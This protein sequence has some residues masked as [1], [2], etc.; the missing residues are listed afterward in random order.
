MKKYLLIVVVGISAIGL[1]WFSK[2]SKEAR[3]E[4]P[5]SERLSLPKIRNQAFPKEKLDP[6]KGEAQ[7]AGATP[8]APVADEKSC[9]T[10]R[11]NLV[12]MDVATLKSQV[13]AGSLKIM[14]GCE[15]WEVPSPL[16][17]MIKEKCKSADIKDQEMCIG[18]MTFYRSL[19]M[20]KMTQNQKDYLTMDIG[21]L[22]NKIYAGFDESKSS[23][24][25]KA[26]FQKMTRALVDRHPYSIQ[27]HKALIGS[28]IKSGVNDPKGFDYK[29]IEAAA[30][31]AMKVNPDEG[32]VH[33]A[34]L[35]AQMQKKDAQKVN[36][37]VT[38]HP[39]SPP[40]L[41]AQAY[42][43]WKDGDHTSPLALLDKA[44]EL[45]PNDPRFKTLRE[46]MKNGGKD[47]QMNFNVNSNL[48]E[49]AEE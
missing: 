6:F 24:V 45:A 27:A 19:W 10:F 43:L 3:S 18:L 40:A 9:H 15:A 20:D 11:E 4:K 17:P 46:Q 42:F 36:E 13:R 34:Y 2:K 48:D 8:S 25:D 38:A 47:M 31:E 33:E 37:F 1:L 28:I 12:A 29:A 21:L 16:I 39:H 30:I 41:Y 22:V 49:E 44:I 7:A 14:E 5:T 32:Q 35:L 26:E 23:A